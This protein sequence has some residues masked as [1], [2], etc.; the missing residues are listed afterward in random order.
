M[1]DIIEID[2]SDVNSIINAFA[3]LFSFV[4]CQITLKE[5]RIAF[6]DIFDE[7]TGVTKHSVPLNILRTPGDGI[8]NEY[9]L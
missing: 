3:D 8:I 2:N 9:S 4:N 5:D 7:V 1:K 6:L